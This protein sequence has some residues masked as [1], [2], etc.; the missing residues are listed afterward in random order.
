MPDLYKA[1]MEHRAIVTRIRDMF[2]DEDDAA[3]ADTVEGASNIKEAITYALRLAREAQAFADAIT[4]MRSELDERRQRYETKA[5]KLRS[6][7][8]QAAVECGETKIVAP[9]F[10]ATVS[11]G[12]RKVIITDEAAV[13]DTMCKIT[14]EPRKSAIMDAIAAGLKPTY[15]TLS[16]PVPFWTLRTK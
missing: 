9:D 13:P 8:L 2:P 4:E 5:E 10:T 7:A 15:A 12:K 1:T 16:N 14:R 6:A 11:P 3:L